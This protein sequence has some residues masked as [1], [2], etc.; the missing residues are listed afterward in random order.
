MKTI[1]MPLHEVAVIAATRALAGAGIGLLAS[2]MLNEEQRKTAGWLLLGIGALSTIPL[3]IS[4]VH[5]LR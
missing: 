2:G 3:A 1:D 5:R 4:M